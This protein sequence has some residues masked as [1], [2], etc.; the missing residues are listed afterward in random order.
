MGLVFISA[1]TPKPFFTGSHR[2]FSL[3]RGPGCRDSDPRTPSPHLTL[4]GLAVCRAVGL[5]LKGSWGSAG[6]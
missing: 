5:L 4:P 6:F 1:P 3:D 2:L